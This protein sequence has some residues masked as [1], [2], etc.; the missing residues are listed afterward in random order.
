MP[1]SRRV[2]AASHAPRARLFRKYVVLF[3]ALVSAA[4]LSSGLVQGYLAYQASVTS[5]G[6]IQR[7]KAAT[8]ATRI[9]QFIE[10]T[11]RQIEDV[12]PP[13][14]LAAEVDLQQRESDYRRLLRRA[15]AITEIRY[16]DAAGREQLSVSRLRMNVVGSGADASHDASFVGANAARTYFSPV[17]FRDNSEPYMTMAIGEGPEG[18]GVTIAELNLKLV[19]EIVSRIKFGQAGYAYVVDSSGHLVAHPDIGLVLQNTNLSGLAQVQAA[20]ASG[21]QPDRRPAAVTAR[22]AHDQ[23]V[24]SAYEAVDPPGWWVFVEQPLDEVFAPLYATLGLTALLLMAG[25]GLSVVV[26]LV[27]TRR[28][29]A[30]I[31][32]L[33]M[34]AARIGAGAL[35]ARIEISTGDELEALAEEFNRMSARLQESHAFLEDKVQARTRELATTLRELGERSGEL[36]VLSQHKSEFLAQMSHELRTPLNSIIGFSELLL[37]RTY[38]ELNERQARYLQHVLAAGQ[39]LLSLINDILDLSKVEAGRMEL[40]RDPF[41]LSDVLRDGLA[42]VRERADR[43]GI[44]LELAVDPGIGSVEADERKVRQVMF[45]LLSN[46]V[47]FTPVG[48]RVDVVAQR[49]GPDVRVAV[50]DTG[51]GVP[52]E[53][54]ARIFEPFRQSRPAP[55]R[56]REGTGLGLALARQFVELHGG[57]M[58]LESEVGVGSTF[59]FTLPCASAVPYMTVGT[60]VTSVVAELQHGA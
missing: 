16:V 12:V 51:I 47:K 13:P 42:V 25:L 50:R 2:E 43:R 58:W 8:A 55:G 23:P 28:V 44:V 19:G 52:L 45:N 35:D 57:R 56:A 5:L 53:D 30:P 9:G 20:A 7:E 59:S 3:V 54:R 24:L 41:V 34:G 36:E 31:Q 11:Q 46:A 40:E 60:P 18:T 15:P 48:G 27:L 14:W 37:E 17:Y 4:L 49:V 10:E 29:V 1:S 38:G 22:D 6:Q 33:R 39:H 26:G 32:A 21:T